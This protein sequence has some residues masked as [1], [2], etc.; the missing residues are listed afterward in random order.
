[1]EEYD[2]N[3]NTFVGYLSNGK[4][5][6]GTVTIPGL[7]KYKGEFDNLEFNG[8]GV[9]EYENGDVYNGDWENNE[10]HGYG[11]M[12]YADG[13][14]YDGGWIAGKRHGEATVTKNGVG[15]REVWDTDAFVRE[16]V[17]EVPITWLKAD[18]TEYN[19]VEELRTDLGFREGGPVLDWDKALGEPKLFAFTFG[20]KKEL[21]IEGR[22]NFQVCSDAQYV[23]QIGPSR[24]LGRMQGFG[25]NY[26]TSTGEEVGF[27]QFLGTKFFHNG[28]LID[29]GEFSPSL[30]LD[31]SH[32]RGHPYC[33]DF[34]D[35]GRR[36]VG[37]LDD[38]GVSKVAFP[39]YKKEFENEV[40]TQEFTADTFLFLDGKP[41]AVGH[42]KTIYTL[43]N[44]VVSKSQ[45][46]LSAN[47]V[48]EVPDNFWTAANNRLT[49][50]QR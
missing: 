10:R 2:L 14:E 12:T 9:M 34:T 44:N 17:P 41:A 43:D 13:T 27:V 49:V 33:K 15:R 7:G 24:F 37:M 47:F 6:D 1:M 39:K 18:E 40:I 8:K 3:G 11:T 50:D 21:E 35:E 45:A 25:F 32:P 36:F 30:E 4:P 16:I 29:D 5:Q 26:D 22:G 48:T 20:D 38:P 42:I 23:K 31:N 46:E 28:T 19:D